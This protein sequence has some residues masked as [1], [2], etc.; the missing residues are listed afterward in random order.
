MQLR[1]TWD[2]K[3]GRQTKIHILV[4]KFLRQPVGEQEKGEKKRKEEEEEEEEEEV[5]G[6]Q[7]Q[8]KFSF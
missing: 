2:F 7:N 6:D 3:R 5:E 4:T 8:G 1:K